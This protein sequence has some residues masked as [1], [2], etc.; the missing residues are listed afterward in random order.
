MKINFTKKQYEDLLKLV[1][2][3]D[4]MTNANRTEDHTERFEEL[5]SYLFSF[6]KDFGLEE[7]ADADD[8]GRVYP[9]RLFEEEIG[10]RELIDEYDN[11]TFWDELPDHLGERDFFEKFTKEE[12]EAMD[13]EKLFMERMECIINW[14]KEFEEHGIERLR[15][16][17][18]TM[19]T[20]KDPSS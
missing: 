15:A 11:E 7:Y 2:M 13:P 9:S 17:N 1:Y 6:A 8:P 12:I 5:E 19:R 4:W 10:L 3:G 14:E 18:M 16:V 20:E